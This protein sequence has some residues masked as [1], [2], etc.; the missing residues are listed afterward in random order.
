MSGRLYNNYLFV[1]A[2]DDV[3]D[4]STTYWLDYITKPVVLKNILYDTP[5]SNPCMLVYQSYARG[6]DQGACPRL[7]ASGFNMAT[8]MCTEMHT[9]Y[10]LSM[11]FGEF[12]RISCAIGGL[13]YFL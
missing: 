12:M 2:L 9:C 11:R 4:C 6:N 10:L 1:Y 7:H 5:V 3:P 8:M 13:S